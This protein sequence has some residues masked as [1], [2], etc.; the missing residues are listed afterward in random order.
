MAYF[1]NGTSGDVLYNQC[2]E[3][4]CGMDATD[5]VACPVLTVQEEYN[6]DQ[7]DKGQEYLR[8]A[9]DL[10]VNG[11]GIC[12]MKKAMEQVGMYFDLSVKNQLNLLEEYKAPK[13]VGLKDRT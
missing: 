3:C 1:P 2:D 8:E 12:Q 6:Y 11:K 10:L 9:M 7:V 4:I 13:F 5:L